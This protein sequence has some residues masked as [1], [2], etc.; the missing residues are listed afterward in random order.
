MAAFRSRDDANADK[1]RSLAP[2]EVATGKSGST[3]A[4]SHA[5]QTPAKASGEI[6][7]L[8]KAI[9]RGDAPGRRRT[10]RDGCAHAEGDA[11][12]TPA[13]ASGKILS[14][15]KA[16]QAGGRRGKERAA[17]H[18]RSSDWRRGGAASPEPDE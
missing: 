8:P 17:R 11:R 15:P 4:E 16:H 1:R 12:Q 6:P 5:R 2:A 9:T 3:A 14:L 7:S 18:E 13:K 10:A